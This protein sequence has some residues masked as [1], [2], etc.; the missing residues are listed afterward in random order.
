MIS[1]SDAWLEAGY[2]RFGQSGPAALQVEKL[3]L[4]VGKSKSSFYH[5]FG[6]GEV[7][8]EGLLLLHQERVVEISRKE[9]MAS[10]L[11]P[12]LLQI[13][14]EHKPDLLFNRQLRIARSLPGFEALI[15]WT[16]Q[17]IGPGFLALWQKE[18]GSTFSQTQIQGF[19][20]LAMDHFY[21]QMTPENLNPEW[22]HHYLMQLRTQLSQLGQRPLD[23]S[24]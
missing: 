3:A 7:F 19:I 2:E 23:G 10:T 9:N 11:V 8:L 16:D 17:Q 21:L 6:N 15:R 18:S 14:V 22:L 20:Q 24:V 12:D 13:L 4:L 1:S 5:H